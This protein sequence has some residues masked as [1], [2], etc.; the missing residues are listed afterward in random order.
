MTQISLG[1]LPF[2]LFIDFSARVVA[3]GYVSRFNGRGNDHVCGEDSHRR[4][5]RE[6]EK[7]S[8]GMQGTVIPF[9]G[10]P[11]SPNGD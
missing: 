7:V 2:I 4:Q 8:L 6:D 11:V 10:L 5:T 3:R 9:K 1:A